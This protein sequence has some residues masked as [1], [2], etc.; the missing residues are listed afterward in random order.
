MAIV[1]V[2]F[3][4]YNARRYGKP[5]VAKITD[6]PVGKHPTLEFGATT[7]LVAEIEAEPGA[8]VRWGQRDYRGKNTEAEWGI[9]R[10]GGV[11]EDATAARCLK[12]WRAGCPA[13]AET[14][15]VVAIKE[16]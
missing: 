13:M 3:Q 1:T 8:I 15:N 5:W 16:A 10:A 11:I 2:T 7:D 14:S 4:S 6:W 9:V 12:H